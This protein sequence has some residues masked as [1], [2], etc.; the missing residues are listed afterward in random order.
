MTMKHEADADYL[1]RKFVIRREL[2][3]PR[4]RVF[5]AWTD[6]RQLARWWGPAGFTN[7]VCEWDVRPG[8]KIYDVMRAPNGMEHAMG[9]EFR[10]IVPPARL[11]LAC[12]ALDG[13]GKLLFEFVHDVNFAEANG[14]TTLTVRSRVTLAGAG[15]GKYIDG[16]EP[17]MSSSLE[18][19]AEL[20]ART[21]EPLVVE[22]TF[23]APAA[24][25]W[26]ALTDRE[27]MKQWYFDLPEFRPEAGF[28]FQFAVEHKGF[29][30][31]HH[32]RVAEAVP[33]R[34]LAYT[35]RYEGHAGGSLVTFELFAEGGRTRLKLTHEGLETFPAMPAF[36]RSSFVDGWTRLIGSALKEFV[37]AAN[38]AAKPATTKN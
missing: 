2:A 12:G 16:F 20:V 6:P 10:E 13:T 35:W 34:K 24:R 28:E 25:V 30:Y 32:C 31:V 19:L 17:G 5:Q 27:Q 37:E 36:A 29:N 21:A 23:N 1:G 22:R 7:P 38:G 18:R 11:V 14:K 4:E 15:S 33:H 3:A 26:Q 8:G 9:G